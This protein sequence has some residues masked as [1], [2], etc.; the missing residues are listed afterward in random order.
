MQRIN[1]T[2]RCGHPF[3]FTSLLES[4]AMYFGRK[5]P[6][7]VRTNTGARKTHFDAKNA[8]YI[9]RLTPD[10][11]RKSCDNSIQSVLISRD[12]PSLSCIDVRVRKA[13]L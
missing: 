3:K 4:P 11:E 6:A 1:Q 10:K 2:G 12:N 5:S 9:S 7:K 13:G 8:F